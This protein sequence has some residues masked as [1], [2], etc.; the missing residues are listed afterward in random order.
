MIYTSLKY[1]G[2]SLLTINIHLKKMNSRR[3]NQVQGWVS[4]GGGGHKER[5][6]EGEYGVCI[7]HL[8][9]Y[10]NTEE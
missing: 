3:E 9:S 6:N 8:H 10:M 5:G 1:Q 2:K 7:L 4:V